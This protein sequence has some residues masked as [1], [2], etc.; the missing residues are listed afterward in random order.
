MTKWNLKALEMFLQE[1]EQSIY[2]FSQ[3]YA[4]QEFLWIHKFWPMFLVSAPVTTEG[5]PGRTE[6]PG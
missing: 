1:A 4:E 6:V 3:V 2:L 5:S